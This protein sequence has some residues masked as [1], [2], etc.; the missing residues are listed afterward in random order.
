MITFQAHQARPDQL[1][2]DGATSEVALDSLSV[3]ELFASLLDCDL[4]RERFAAVRMIDDRGTLEREHRLVAEATAFVRVQGAFSF[5]ELPDPRACVDA[6]GMTGYALESRDLLDVALFLERAG[7]LRRWVMGA[8]GNGDSPELRALAT[9]LP[10]LD[11]LA[12]G[13]R[14]RYLPS[15]ELDDRAS[16]VLQRIRRSMERQRRT[17]ESALHQQMRRL[18]ADDVLQEELITIRGERL[19]LPVRVEHRRRVQGILHGSSSTGQTLYVE[20]LE[21]IEL[22]NELVALLEEEQEEMRRIRAE[23]TA[24]VAA[25][26]GEVA[27]AASGLGELE[28]QLAKGRFAVAYEAGAAE[29]APEDER[30]LEMRGARHPLLVATLRGGGRRVVPLDLKL[31]AARVLVISGPNAG[32]KTVALKTVGVAAWMAQCGLPVCAT[33]AKLPLFDRILAD[34]GDAQSLAES[35]STFS[36]HLLHL[37]HILEVASPRSLVAL[38]ELGAATDPAEGAALAV[39][40]VEELQKR[41]VFALISTHHGGLKTFVASAKGV[42]NASVGFDEATL[43]PTFEL[44]VG[45]AGVSAGLDMAQR[46]GLQPALVAAA[47][48][49]LSAADRLAADYLRQLQEQVAASERERAALRAQELALSRK[50]ERIESEDR[51]ERQKQLA[52]MQRRFEG[53]LEQMEGKMRA[54][55]AE[56][57]DKAAATRLQR[58]IG[59]KVPGLRREGQDA[60]RAEMVQHLG[61]VAPDAPTVASPVA[62]HK[63]AAQVGVGDRVRLNGVARPGEVVRCDGDHLEVAVGNL[64]LRAERHEII[65]VLP[66]EAT[67]PNG[68]AASVRLRTQ[69]VASSGVAEL[70][71][72]GENAEE[73]LRRLD[74]FLDNAVLA[75]LP[76]VR[77]VHG[78]GMGV[79]RRAVAQALKDHAAVA[80]FYQ[81]PQQEGGGGV[82]IAEMRTE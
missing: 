3:R 46:L 26:A 7:D 16:P 48:Q 41:G 73:A 70:N 80:R 74:K 56:V 49:R 19:V 59:R 67:K 2:P 82:T 47:R 55:L 44:R 65:E 29:F 28:F 69:P 71:L 36:S 17:I 76:Q 14:R 38:D 64:R 63:T 10:V 66:P 60:L 20:P 9:R 53:L 45:M 43:Q 77:I 24:A 8:S 34:I 31:D 13:I 22:N 61:G 54:A 57:Q 37:R 1:D 15:G 42:L 51:R 62:F 11:E 35:L 81:P 58:E 23:L 39:A 4:G 75:E 5:V 52:E 32:G 72:I 27:R 78:S 12:Q 40:V 21:T 50:E 30:V 18:A 25:Q 68:G 33:Y 6:A 79:L